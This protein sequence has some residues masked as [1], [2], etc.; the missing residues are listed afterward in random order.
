MEMDKIKV[1]R[2]ARRCAALVAVAAVCAG[3]LAANP[4]PVQGDAYDVIVAGGGPAGIG[5]GYMAATR[6]P[7]SVHTIS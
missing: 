6:P 5:A 1:R 7:T 2:N 3:A 4:P